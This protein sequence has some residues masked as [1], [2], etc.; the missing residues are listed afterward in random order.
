MKRMRLENYR[1]AAAAG[2]RRLGP[3]PNLT[4]GSRT[5]GPFKKFPGK[6]PDA[7]SRSRCTQRLSCHAPLKNR[8]GMHDGAT[9]S[10]PPG[11]K[12]RYPGADMV[13]KTGCVVC[14]SLPHVRLPATMLLAKAP[15]RGGSELRRTG[16]DAMAPTRRPK[17]ARCESATYRTRSVGR[18]PKIPLE[19]CADRLH[20]TT[21]LDGP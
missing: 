12:G 8:S 3:T 13:E 18:I 4:V 1:E 15:N 2:L 11:R 16:R 19:C 17:S 10:A 6:F 7:R 21:S 14:P 9:S 20:A 5:I